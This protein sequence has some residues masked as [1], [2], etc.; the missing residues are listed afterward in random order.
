MLCEGII[1]QQYEKDEEEHVRGKKKEAKKH[2]PT[3]PVISDGGGGNCTRK[4]P[5]SENLHKK[6][7]A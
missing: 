1:W 2:P 5:H 3:H 4:L 7:F 6:N